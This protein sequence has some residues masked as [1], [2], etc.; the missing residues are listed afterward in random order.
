M[1][2]NPAI[3]EQGGND[4][5]NGYCEAVRDDAERAGEARLSRRAAE[6]TLA[7]ILR[8]KDCAGARD[9]VDGCGRRP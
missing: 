6:M 3:S 8:P 1:R 9:G 2:K 7:E 4:C 5:A